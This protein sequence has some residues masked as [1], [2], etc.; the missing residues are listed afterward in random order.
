[1]ST[2]IFDLAEYIIVAIVLGF[3]LYFF[4][5]TRAKIRQ[6]EGV[7]PDSSDFTLTEA[8]ILKSDL[9]AVPPRQLLDKLP[10]YVSRAAYNTDAAMITLTLLQLQNT[11]SNESEVLTDIRLAINT[12]LIRNRGAVSDFNLLRDIVQR[13]LDAIE[14]EISLTTP[15]P[16]YLGLA[17]TMAGI[18][19]GLY[20]L[21]DMNSAAFLEGSGISSLLNGVKI[22]MIASLMGLGLTVITNGFLFRGTKNQVERR[23]NGFFTFLQ[24][25]LLPVLTENVNSGIV[26]LNRSLDRFGASFGEQVTRLDG[27]MAKNY[28]SLMAQQSAMDALQQMDMVRVASFNLKVLGE[29]K[30]S[31]DALERLGMALKQVDGFVANARALV[32]RTNDIV[33]VADQI[34]EVLNESRQLQRYLNGHFS[35]L[36]TRGQLINDTVVRLDDVVSRSLKDL[37]SHIFARIEAVKQIEITEEDLM[38]KHFDDNRDALGQLR[39]L[40]QLKNNLSRYASDSEKQQQGLVNMTQNLYLELTALNQSVSTYITNQE[41]AKLGNRIKRIFGGETAKSQRN[42]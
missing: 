6:F 37:E 3:Q 30:T 21:P 15:I 7:I 9:Q 14:E 26:G 1:M 32:D 24:T 19:V 29:L 2:S 12:Y 8:V 16:V 40:E 23:K 28:D 31:V 13:H 41:E 38:K 11:S 39:N 22:A 20:S 35:E 17:G 33:G 18:I 4:G 34:R 25:E 27:L 5:R 36:E 42:G 10:D